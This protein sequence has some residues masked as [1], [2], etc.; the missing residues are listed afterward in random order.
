MNEKQIAIHTQKCY[1]WE[2]IPKSLFTA[3]RF[4]KQLQT[5]VC[6]QIMYTFY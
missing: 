6:N 5:Y 1:I 4:Q 3:N 2:D